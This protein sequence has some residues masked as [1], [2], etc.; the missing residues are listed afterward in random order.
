MAIQITEVGQ[1]TLITLQTRQTTYQMKVDEYG[2]LLHVYYGERVEGEDLSYL[3]RM[4]DRAFSPNPSELGIQIREYSL[5]ILP[6][7]YPGTDVGDFRQSALQVRIAG[8]TGLKLQFQRLQVSKGKYTLEGLPAVYADRDRAETLRIWMEDENAGI[9][10]CLLYGVLPEADVITRACEV[11]NERNDAVLLEKVLSASLDLPPEP[12]DWITFSG[13][14]E[15]ERQPVREPLYPGIHAVESRRGYSSHQANPF[16]I[17]AA[18]DTT[19]D[20][21]FCIGAELVY[22]GCFLALAERSQFE[23]VRLVMGIHPE[24]FSWE[25]A[26]GESFNAPEVIFTCTGKGLNALSRNY[27]RL[28]RNHVCRGKYKDVRRPV[29]INNWEATYFDFDGDKIE[30]IARKAAELGVEL[31]VLDDGWFGKRNDDRSSLG[32]WFVNEAKLKGTIREVVQRVNALGMKFGLW[33]EPEMVSEDSC[34]YREHPE[35]A[36][37]VPGR[38]PARGRGQLVLDLSRQDVRDYLFEQICSVLDSA[39]IEYVKWDANRHLTDVYSAGEQCRSQGEVRHRYILGL[40]ELLERLTARY[41]DILWEGCSG[42]GGRFDAGMLYY[43]P[44]IWCSDN[45]DA[46]ARVRIQHGTSYGYPISAVGA[47]VS[48]VP[49]HQTGRVTPLVTRGITAMS[50]TFGFILDLNRLT[51]EEKEEVRRQIADFKE[52][53]ELI[54]WG[55]YFRLT[56]A[57]DPYRYTCWE[58]AAEDGTE[59]LLQAVRPLA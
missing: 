45:T 27:H 23:D 5:D 47:L 44:Q 42:G 49:N 48:A 8:Y 29:L 52:M 19:E 20:N 51:E 33:F 2:T 37:Q 7:E 24:D 15:M 35:W 31:L 46:A 6:Q 59:A 18:P 16:V 9:S 13:R 43:H 57:D 55:L 3:L 14:H 4:R 36:L 34:L 32:D 17:A 10:V 26:P 25:L 1:E 40:Y 39:N 50:G 21:G 38:E 28:Y 30:A 22:S 54:Q 11:T 58:F 53:Y 56:G 41:P 12:F